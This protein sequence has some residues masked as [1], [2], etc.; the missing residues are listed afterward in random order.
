MKAI[1]Y[2]LKGGFSIIIA[3]AIFAIFNYLIMLVGDRADK[4]AELYAIYGLLLIAFSYTVRW[5]FELIFGSDGRKGSVVVKYDNA[6]PAGEK[7]T[8]SATVKIDVDSHS[9]N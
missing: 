7:T 1:T 4:N 8:N 3:L 5:V 6:T 9:S 2:V